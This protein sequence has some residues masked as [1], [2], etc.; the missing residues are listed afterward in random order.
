MVPSISFSGREC[1]HADKIFAFPARTEFSVTTAARPTDNGEED[2]HKISVGIEYKDH[3]RG[4][5]IDV[6]AVDQLITNIGKTP[7]D[8]AML[9]GRLGFTDAAL[10]AS[11]SKEPVAVELL[12]LEGIDAWINRLERGKPDYA[13]QVQILIKSISHEFAKLVSQ[14]PDALDH[15]EWRDVERMMACDGRARVR[16]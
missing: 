12:D 8:R 6:D 10:E 14:S 11:R 13:E 9:I 5:P 7:Y 4:R 16:M 2:A 15:L 1:R 3:G